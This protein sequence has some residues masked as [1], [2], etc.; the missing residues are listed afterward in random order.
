MKQFHSN[1]RKIFYFFMVSIL[2]ITMAPATA[3]ASTPSDIANHWAKVQIEDWVKKGL[4]NGYGDGSFQPDSKISR[5]EFMT[6]INR[7]FGYTEKTNIDYKD[8]KPGTWIAD[9]VS[10]GKAAGYISG[11]SDGTI[12]PN[13]FIS[14][15]EAASIIAKVTGITPNTDAA[16]KLP[17]AANIPAWSKGSIGAV[18]DAGIMGGY[19]DGSFKAKSYITRAEAVVAITNA[20]KVNLTCSKAGTYGPTTGLQT[21]KGS[22]TVSADQVVL[23]NMK[24]EGRLTL[25]KSIGE[26]EVSLKNV[27]VVGD[28]EIL[29]GGPNSIIAINSSFGKV[30]VYKENGK[31]RIVAS[32]STSIGQVTANSGLKLEEKELTG[33]GFREVIIDAEEN[34]TIT[35]SGSF[36][37][38]EIQAEGVIIDVPSGSTVNSM[39][40]DRK[41]SIT[42][43]GT[44]EKAIIGANGISFSK[45]PVSMER[46]PNINPPAITGSGS[47]GGGGGSS[48]GNSGNG[49]PPTPQLPAPAAPV[50]P[51]SDDFYNTFGWTLV[52]GFENATDY[53][54]TTNGGISWTTCSDNP[55]AGFDGI[56]SAGNVKVRV[57][58]NSVLGRPAGQTLQALTGFTANADVQLTGLVLSGTPSGFNF[59]GETYNYDNVTVPNNQATI[60]VTPTLAGGNMSIT[61]EIG[62]QT[63]NSGQTSPSIDLVAGTPRRIVLSVSKLGYHTK[64]YEIYVTRQDSQAGFTSGPQVANVTLP[65]IIT[66]NLTVD[67]AATAYYAVVPETMSGYSRPVPTAKLVK[68]VGT[69]GEMKPDHYGVVPILAG[70]KVSLTGQQAEQIEIQT[71]DKFKASQTYSVFLVLETGGGVLSEVTGAN[72]NTLDDNNQPV[73]N[74]IGNASGVYL[75]KARSLIINEKVIDYDTGYGLYIWAVKAADAPAATPSAAEVKL[76]GSFFGDLNSGEEYT[77]TYTGLDPMTAYKVYMAAQDNSGTGEGLWSEVLVDSATTLVDEQGPDRAGMSDDECYQFFNIGQ[78]KNKQMTIQLDEPLY[79]EADPSFYTALAENIR[80]FDGTTEQTLKQRGDTVTIISNPVIPVND[81]LQ[82][83]FA[84]PPTER[85]QLSV[86]SGAIQDTDNPKHANKYEISVWVDVPDITGPA[87][88]ADLQNCIVGI[89]RQSITMEVSTNENAAVFWVLLPNDAAAPEYDSKI[90]DNTVPSTLQHGSLSIN[91]L[92]QGVINITGLDAATDYDLWISATDAY[93]NYTV[94]S[95]IE[96]KTTN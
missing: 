35:L 40:L 89:D 77:I 12:K 96:F 29:G 44:I 47:S 73:F 80:F 63:I 93:H 94:K 88:S 76:N 59:N 90:I 36:E 56:I 55:Q 87:F 38:A 78:I 34:D 66:V 92:E 75:K 79:Q 23:Q 95:K 33:N 39:T 17:D 46:E 68:A 85:F 51:I 15:Q 83:T 53:E 27:T 72:F 91:Q 52:T 18:L 81:T 70:G 61:Y 54:F 65:G 7:G 25:A 1:K 22:V 6:L 71:N 62:G 3:F 19:P 9:S 60:T 67:K 2:I 49:T 4:I 48:S 74:Q 50:N 14:R 69:S 57:K 24:I 21:V 43:D 64:Q 10:I 11:Y 8:V 16:A 58:A 5:A 31:I 32:G 37:S 84:N 45:A 86:S 20:L 41:A 26:G 28:A 30:R 82:I 42:G 13:E